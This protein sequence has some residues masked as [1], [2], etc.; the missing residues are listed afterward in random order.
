MLTRIFHWQALFAVILLLGM[1]ILTGWQHFVVP[2]QRQLFEYGMCLLAA[3]LASGCLLWVKQRKRRVD[4]RRVLLLLLFSLVCFAVGQLILPA[5]QLVYSVKAPVLVPAGL[6]LLGHLLLGTA[7]VLGAGRYP[8]SL[9]GIV[10]IT[11]DIILTIGVFLLITIERS[12]D[13]RLLAHGAGLAATALPWAYAGGMLLTAVTAVL[14]MSTTV[15]TH[16]HGPRGLLLLGVGLMIGGDA[17]QNS[18]P[19]IQAWGDYPHAYLCWTVGVLFIGLATIWELK[20]QP[21]DAVEARTPDDYLNALGIA[22][23]GLL[24]IGESAVML[25]LGRQILHSPHALLLYRLETSLLLLVLLRFLLHMVRSRQ[26]YAGLLRRVRESEQMAVTD[27]L[28]GVPNKRACLQRLEDELARATRYQRS[29]T[30]IFCDIDYF[31]MIN[32]VHGHHVGDQALCAVANVLHAKIRT[33]D[34]MGR[35]GGEEFLF[36]LPETTL[37]QATILAERLRQAVAEIRLPVGPSHHLQMTMSFGLSSYP[38]TSETLDDL[39]QDADRAMNH[40]KETGRNRV[41]L[42]RAKLNLYLVRQ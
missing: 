28:T 5:I 14:A 30:V 13:H 24:L 11:C 26:A 34:L 4:E 27:Q 38:E 10:T 37:Q 2:A 33:T 8:R 36:I 15:S 16:Q 25:A 21:R 17:A 39:L 40:A 41:V 23:P 42:S 6:F 20:R 18:F 29:F 31:K 19:I 1:A 32:D 3:L 22:L 7:L 9:I 35:F 12:L